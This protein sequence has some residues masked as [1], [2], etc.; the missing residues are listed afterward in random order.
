MSKKLTP[1]QT[2]LVRNLSKGMS[3]TDAALKSGYSRKAPGQ[4]GHQALKS[5]RDKMPEVLDKAGL[6][7]D[8]LIEQYLKPIMTAETT[9]LVRLD[10]KITDEVKL[11]SWGHR[12][13]GLD[14]AFKLKGLYAS[15]AE[16]VEGGSTITV[17]VLVMPDASKSES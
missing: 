9:E 2:L 6:T 8:V 5:I 7:D 4:S 16:G 13:Q 14:M 12:A 15:K 10:G 17:N 1:Q 11:P 3:I